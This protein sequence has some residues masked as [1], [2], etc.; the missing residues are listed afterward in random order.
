[1]DESHGKLAHRLAQLEKRFERLE[2][3]VTADKLQEAGRKRRLRWTR[4][5]F[6]V[7]L[8]LIYAYYIS[9]IDLDI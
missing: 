7:G 1:M 3:S 9:A 2:Q 8:G 4:L 6:Y 5:A